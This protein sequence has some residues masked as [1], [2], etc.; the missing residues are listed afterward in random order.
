MLKRIFSTKNQYYY[1]CLPHLVIFIIMIYIIKKLK[2]C[3]FKECIKFMFVFVFKYTFFI[4][5]LGVFLPQLIAEY[6]R[7]IN[8]LDGTPFIYYY[9]FIMILFGIHLIKLQEK[10]GL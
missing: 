9:N 7:G 4:G 1:L 5:I 10:E 8:L 2:K 3:Y 6:F